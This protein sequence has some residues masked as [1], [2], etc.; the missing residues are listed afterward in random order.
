MRAVADAI[1]ESGRFMYSSWGATLDVEGDEVEGIST[2]NELAA[3][4]TLRKCGTTGCI[5]GWAATLAL[6]EN[7]MLW[8][9]RNM[10]I[11]DMAEAYLDLTTTEAHVLFLGQAMV[12][13]GFYEGDGEA[14][15]KGTAIEAAKVLRMV[16]DGEVVL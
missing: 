3:V 9:R 7:P 4:G 8:G 6:E 11:S 12:L 1:E 15:A 16:A 10:M 14:L 2:T 5:A 13:A